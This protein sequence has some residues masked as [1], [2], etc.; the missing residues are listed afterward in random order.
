MNGSV[1]KYPLAV[2]DEDDF[3]I[4]MK[5]GAQILHLDTQ[6]GMPCLW[7]LVDPNAP[8][9]GRYFHIAGT[10]HPIEGYEFMKHIG[11]FMLYGGSL[12]FHVFEQ[13]PSRYHKWFQNKE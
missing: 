9:E 12:V 5:K 3:K 6:Q 4:E 1:W 7:A 2:T 11:S 8:V 13:E 10:G